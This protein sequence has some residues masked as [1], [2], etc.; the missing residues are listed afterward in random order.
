MRDISD[1]VFDELIKCK[2]YQNNNNIQ[3]TDTNEQ[4]LES[5]IKQEVEYSNLVRIFKNSFINYNKTSYYSTIHR[6]QNIYN[7]HHR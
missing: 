5:S 7:R 1:I 3:T 4:N 2:I 6:Y